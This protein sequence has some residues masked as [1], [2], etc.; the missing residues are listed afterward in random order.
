MAQSVTA[1]RFL[2]RRG[3]QQFIKF[4]VIGFS[5]MLI[6][7]GI[8]GYLTYQKS[9]IW[10]VAKTLS[11][12]IAV[13]NGYVWNS[14]WTFRGMGAGRRHELYAKFVAVNLVGYVLNLGLMKAMFIAFTG[15]LIQKTTPDRTHWLVA[16]AFA[17]AVVSLWNFLANKLWT[18]RDHKQAGSSVSSPP[19][20]D[21]SR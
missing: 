1:G 13:T 15:Q 9:W 14:M 19:A 5:S 2:E 12:S 6:D 20:S 4:C 8:S 17:V 10:W 21:S 16:T 3:V 11:F 7:V 18:F